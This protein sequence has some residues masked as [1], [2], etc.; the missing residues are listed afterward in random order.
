MYSIIINFIL[1]QRLL[2]NKLIKIS[3]FIS[4]Y[5]ENILWNNFLIVLFVINLDCHFSTLSYFMTSQI[6]LSVKNLQVF[7]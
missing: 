5:I 7:V 6:C 3:K 4:D 2:L 1:F